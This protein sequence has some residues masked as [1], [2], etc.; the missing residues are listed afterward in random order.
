M[1]PTLFIPSSLQSFL[2]HN[3]YL[4]GRGLLDTVTLSFRPSIHLS[5]MYPW[6]I[7]QEA[8]NRIKKRY[9]ADR[10]NDAIDSLTC[11]YRN[12]FKVS[13]FAL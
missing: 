5:N 9:P 11:F 3:G 10:Y 1:E 12:G 7:D 2:A 6:T 4:K 13:S 8:I